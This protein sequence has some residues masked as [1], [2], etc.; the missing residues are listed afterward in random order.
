MDIVYFTRR[1]GFH[2]IVSNATNNIWCFS[3][4]DYEVQVIQD[5]DQFLHLK[6]SCGILPEDIFCTFIY[7]KCS[8]NPRRILWEELKTLSNHK[9]PWLVGG[10]FNAILHTEENMGGIINR[11]GPL[12][13]FNDMILESGLTDA[14]F[15]GEPFTWTNKR[16]WRR[17]D[18]VLYSK[19]WTDL[20]NITRV[21]H[22]SRRLS[23]HHPL[24]ITA[25][26]T[27]NRWPSSFRFQQ[28]WVSHQNFLETAKRWWSLPIHGSGMYKLQQK[29]Y[30]MK[31]H[32]KMWNKQTF[33]NIFSLVD[34]AKSAASEAE[35]LFDKNP[36]DQ[37]LISLNQKKCGAGP[38]PQH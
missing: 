21:T 25:D 14:G 7:A 38:C 28:M 15:E 29:L 13:D 33:G 2:A 17:L 20:F 19:D 26:R 4:I 8:R 6:V 10:D 24:L 5:H 11:L 12:E 32:L 27:E 36:C 31:E 37:H 35:I 1:F 18:R 3:K 9:T 34:Q 23:D 22:L 16:V 30:R